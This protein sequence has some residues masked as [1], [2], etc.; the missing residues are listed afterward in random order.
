M[1]KK[2]MHRLHRLTT[3]MRWE[4]AGIWP[5]H[6]QPFVGDTSLAGGGSASTA[7]S[8]AAMRVAKLL[9]STGGWLEWPPADVSVT[10]TLT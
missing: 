6:H 10:L 1:W 2:Q 8:S 9:P 4:R 7:D 5:K 3:V